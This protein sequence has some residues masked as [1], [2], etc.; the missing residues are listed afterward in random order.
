MQAFL[1]QLDHVVERVTVVGN[2]ELRQQDPA[3]L[4]LDVAKIDDEPGPEEQTQRKQEAARLTVKISA[5]PERLQT[6]LA[7][8]YVEGCTYREIAHMLNVSEPRVCQLH[9][10]AVALLRG[11][12]NEKVADKDDAA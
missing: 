1:A 4:D 2:R 12:L 5:L 10:E 8:H 9:A 11:A 6:V 7:L 3:E